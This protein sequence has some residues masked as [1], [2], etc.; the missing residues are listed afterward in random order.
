MHVSK[1]TVLFASF[2]LIVYGI[3]KVWLVF[4]LWKANLRAYPI[5]GV[6]LGLLIVYQLYRVSYTHSLFLLL[7]TL[8][9]IGILLLLRRE[10][11]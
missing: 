3:I 4:S 5:A 7:V 6:I 1:G 10:Y 8:V 2:Y 11:L 9:D